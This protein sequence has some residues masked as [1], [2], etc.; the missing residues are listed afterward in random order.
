MIGRRRDVPGADWSRRDFTFDL[1]RAARLRDGKFEPFAD[2]EFDPQ[3][4]RVTSAEE[5]ADRTARLH[6]LRSAA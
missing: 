1:A 4:Q 6:R 2:P 5:R 3:L